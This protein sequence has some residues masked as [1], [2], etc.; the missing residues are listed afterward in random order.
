MLN[1]GYLNQRRV[2][3]KEELNLIDFAESV[4]FVCKYYGD[5]SVVASDE[6]F[7]HMVLNI[8]KKGKL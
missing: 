2:D 8:Y 7:V 1:T 6:D 5:K 4:N 3:L